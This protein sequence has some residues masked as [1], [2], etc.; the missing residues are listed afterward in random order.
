MVRWV[1]LGWVAVH[2]WGDM[3]VAGVKRIWFGN[4]GLVLIATRVS[5]VV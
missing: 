4:D 2:C 3:M 5:G 1:W